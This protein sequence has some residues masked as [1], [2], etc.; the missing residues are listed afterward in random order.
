MFKECEYTVGMDEL[1]YVFV[2]PGFG[3]LLR[4]GRGWVVEHNDPTYD[5]NLTKPQARILDRLKER[6]EGKVKV[7]VLEDRV[8]I[9]LDGE[10]LVLWKDGGV[11]G[12]ALLE[13]LTPKP[14]P[15]WARL[16]S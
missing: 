14:R 11:S 15:W 16:F 5:W 9:S 2:Y 10:S 4:R 13:E 12:G 1:G 6:F 3:A 8:R 7:A